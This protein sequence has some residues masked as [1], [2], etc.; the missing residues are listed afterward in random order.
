MWNHYSVIH[1]V[2]RDFLLTSPF[3]LLSYIESQIHVKYENQYYSIPDHI[4]P[5]IRSCV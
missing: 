5:V 2:N 4:N 1:T 3:C